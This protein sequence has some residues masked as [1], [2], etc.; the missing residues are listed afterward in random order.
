MRMKPQM[1]KERCYISAGRVRM[2]LHTNPL[3]DQDGLFDAEP[4]WV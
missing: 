2:D 3:P 4:A 1:R